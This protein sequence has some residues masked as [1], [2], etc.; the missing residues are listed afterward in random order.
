[1]KHW[2]PPRAA[3]ARSWAA[4]SGLWQD[5]LS[6]WQD[7]LTCPCYQVTFPVPCSEPGWQLSLLLFQEHMNAFSLGSCLTVAVSFPFTHHLP[8]PSFILA[9]ICRNIC[10]VLVTPLSYSVSPK[11]GFPHPLLA[12]F[13]SHSFLLIGIAWLLANLT[14]SPTYFDFLVKIVLSAVQFC[15]YSLLLICT[16]STY[17]NYLPFR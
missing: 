7:S 12:C 8:D 2:P 10:L 9:E 14:L 16:L 15:F 17:S 11:A 1:M 4:R 5:P 3:P 6:P 13:Y